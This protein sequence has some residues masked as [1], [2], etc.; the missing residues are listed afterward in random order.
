M[1]HVSI[2]ST[3]YYLSFFAPIA[4]AASERFARHCAPVLGAFDGDGG[5]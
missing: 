5:V 2:V 4:E 3:A 1:G